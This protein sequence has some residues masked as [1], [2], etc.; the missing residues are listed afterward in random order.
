[1]PSESDIVYARIRT[2]GIRK[3]S[4]EI[5]GQVLGCACMMLSCECFIMNRSRC[6]VDSALM[7]LP[8]CDVALY[9]RD[10]VSSTVPSASVLC[11][12]VCVLFPRH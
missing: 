5:D 4:L 6:S 7:N 12:C 11:V 8:Q 2:T 10:S 1:V 9:Y 3:D